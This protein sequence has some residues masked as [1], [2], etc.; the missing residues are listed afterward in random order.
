MSRRIPRL[1]AAGTMALLLA[2]CASTPPRVVRSGV[3]PYNQTYV[4]HGRSYDV[5]PTA[6]GYH[7]RGIASW[8]GPKF[9]G[10]KTSNGERY[11]MYAMTAASRDLPLPS[12]VRVTNLQNGR[13][14]VVKVN[15]RGPFVQDRIIDLSYAAAKKLGMIGPGTALV[16]VQV[17]NPRQPAVNPPPPRTQAQGAPAPRLFLQVGA[18]SSADNAARHKAQLAARGFRPLTVDAGTGA[19]GRKLYRVRLGPLAN[20]DALDAAAER[21]R[22]FGIK[23]FQVAV[24]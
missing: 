23:G 11:N 5:L 24:D 22:E 19:N 9:H 6:V 2:A 14:V 10:R 13:Q 17:V 1:F 18:F 3:P 12:W 15:D 8:Y 20:V 16:E 21:L 4:V 7:R